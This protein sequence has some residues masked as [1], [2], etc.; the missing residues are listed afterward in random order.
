MD[1]DLLVAHVNDTLAQTRLLRD[2]ATA[3]R[4]ESTRT[5]SRALILQTAT[6]RTCRQRWSGVAS[7]ASGG[8]GD[9]VEPLSADDLLE[10][11]RDAIISGRLPAGIS[12]R[13][14][15][16]PI[17]GVAACAI[18]ERPVRET[19]TAYKLE[20]GDDGPATPQTFHLHV[21]CFLVWARERRR[22]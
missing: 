3:L 14:W 20:F 12:Y 18:C 8:S 4:A 9:G 22:W 7:L 19:E 11:A 10:C 15:D 21:P 1:V 2:R 13:S 6:S 17:L 16:G 5:R